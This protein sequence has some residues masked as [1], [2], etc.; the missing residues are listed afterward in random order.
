MDEWILDTFEIT[1]FNDI[2]SSIGFD[3]LDNS[4]EETYLF[5]PKAQIVL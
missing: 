5:A 4:K 2:K 1:L 3:W